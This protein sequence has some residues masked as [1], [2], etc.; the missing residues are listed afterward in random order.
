MTFTALSFNYDLINTMPMKFSLNIAFL[1][2]I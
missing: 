2:F 1:M